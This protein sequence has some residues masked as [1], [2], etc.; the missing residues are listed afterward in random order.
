MPHWCYHTTTIAVAKESCLASNSNI[1][2]PPKIFPIQIYSSTKGMALSSGKGRPR[3]V[4]MACRCAISI[5]WLWLLFLMATI[6]R[7]PATAFVTH[8]YTYS[9]RHGHASSFLSIS[10]PLTDYAGTPGSSSEVTP[11]TPGSAA[12]PKIGIL[13]LN[14]GGPETLDDVEGRS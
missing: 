6:V 10:V 3:K 7:R 8:P 14:L 13:L 9:A 4:L 11:L 12:F 2:P 5:A 1:L